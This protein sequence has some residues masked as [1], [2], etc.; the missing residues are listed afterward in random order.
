MIQYFCEMS[1]IF[2]SYMP[3]PVPTGTGFC[4]LII[5]VQ[6]TVEKLFLFDDAEKKLDF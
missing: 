6:I 2:G 5:Q 4:L 3:V 1:S